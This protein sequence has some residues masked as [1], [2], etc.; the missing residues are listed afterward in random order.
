ADLAAGVLGESLLG[1]RLSLDAAKAR[2][3]IET[4][5]A[6]LRL[7][8]EETILGVQRVVRAS[9]AKAMRLILARR[10][11]DPRESGLLA[12]GGAGP[13]HAWA[14]AREIGVRTVLVPFLPGAFSAYGILISPIRLEYGRSV[15]RPLEK[16]EKVIGSS[17]QEFRSR[18]IQDLESQGHD[19]DRAHFEASADLRFRGQSYEIN[20]PLRGD[21]GRAFRREHRRRYGYA[22][23]TEPIELVTIRFVARLPRRIHLPSPPTPR[24]NPP[25]RRRVLFEDGWLET[26]VYH[27]NDLGPGHEIAGPAIVEE[28]YATTLVPPDARVRIDRAGLL[29]IEVSR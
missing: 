2:T 13:M 1:G 24:A 12:F 15:V 27:R 16:A 4:L 6:E 5:A 23:P 9:M 14:L 26:T 21:L 8:L 22:S 7:S 19:P 11:V 18:V 20:V 28:E 10:G 3:G 29:E 17:V 25:Y